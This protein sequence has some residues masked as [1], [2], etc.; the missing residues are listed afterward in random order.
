MLRNGEIEPV[1]AGGIIAPLA[2]G[3]KVRWRRLDLDDDHVAVAIDRRDIGAPS[4]RQSELGYAR[5]A[6]RAQ[7]PPH[8]AGDHQ[9]RLRL[10]PVR[11][12]GLHFLPHH[13]T[14]ASARIISAAFSAI[15]IV[16]EPVLPE[17]MR[18][19]TDASTTRNPPRPWTLSRSSTTANRSCANPIFAVPM[20]WKIV[21]PTS[22]AAR[23]S[24]SSDCGFGP[25]LSSWGA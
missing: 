3:A 18:G 6:A 1:A 19:I 11:R 10:A 17:V 20:G 12:K 16:G 5:E 9:R 22:P 21:V 25:G 23:I 14:P 7:Q 13:A 4:V 24:S 8:P 15:I 2:V